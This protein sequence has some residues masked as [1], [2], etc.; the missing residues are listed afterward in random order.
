[1]AVTA[2][3]AGWAGEMGVWLLLLGGFVLA[4][5]PFWKPVLCFCAARLH[6][7]AVMCCVAAAEPCL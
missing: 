2:F 6:A 4:A 3:A 7:A 1:M 5:V